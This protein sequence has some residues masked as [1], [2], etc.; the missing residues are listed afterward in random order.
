MGTQDKS[1]VSQ[2]EGD[3]ERTRARLAATVDELAYRVQPST[4]LKRETEAAKTS[5]Y[6]ATRSSDGAIRYEV[7][8]PVVAVV[9]GLIAIAIIRRAR[10]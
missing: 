8:G 3:I 6:K 9:V 4:L 1:S 10:A 5:F 7:V 2:I